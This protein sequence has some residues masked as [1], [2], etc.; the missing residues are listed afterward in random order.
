MTKTLHSVPTP[1]SQTESPQDTSPICFH[2]RNSSDLLGIHPSFGDTSDPIAI[3]TLILGSHQTLSQQC[4]SF[5][6]AIMPSPYMVSCSYILKLFDDECW[7]IS[8]SAEAIPI[9]GFTIGCPRTLWPSMLEFRVH[10]T[11]IHHTCSHFRI[12]SHAFEF[13]IVFP[14]FFRLHRHTFRFRDFAS[15]LGHPYRLFPTPQNPM[16]Y[17]FS[18]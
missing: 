1:L 15:A 4:K 17:M 10:L 18:F 3:N 2:C 12:S 16:T 5:M 9:Q 11:P 7:S 8:F 6:T 13:L 14:D